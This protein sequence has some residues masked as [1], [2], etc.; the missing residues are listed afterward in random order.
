MNALLINGGTMENVKNVYHDAASMQRIKLV[1]MN[2][3]FNVKHNLA[4]YTEQQV[5]NSTGKIHSSAVTQKKLASFYSDYNEQPSYILANYD[6]VGL[7]KIGSDVTCKEGFV[8]VSRVVSGS[9]S[10]VVEELAEKWVSDRVPGIIIA[11]N[12][13]QLVPIKTNPGTQYE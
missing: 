1:E 7:S 5:F 10:C 12:T 9:Q 4:D 8:M 2:S 13:S 6:D 11:D 3:Q